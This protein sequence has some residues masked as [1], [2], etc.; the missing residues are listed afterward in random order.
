MPGIDSRVI[1]YRLAIDLK[2][3]PMAQKKRKLILEKQKVAMQETK[4]LLR[5][6][7]IKEVHFTTWLANMVMVPKS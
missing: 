4:K 3:R 2:V 7:F 6:S 1:Y 5:A